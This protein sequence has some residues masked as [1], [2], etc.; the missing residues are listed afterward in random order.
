MHLSKK[1]QMAR[2]K[3]EQ[4][5]ILLANRIRLLRNEEAKTR[6]KIVETEK[7]TQEIIDARRRNEKRRQDKEAFEAHKEALE[8]EFRTKQMM[9]RADQQHK[10]QD[11]LRSIRERN[12][13]AGNVIRQER[14]AYQEVVDFERQAAAD[15]AFARAEQVRAAM[16]QAARTVLMASIMDVRMYLLLGANMRAKFSARA[17]FKP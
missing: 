14:Q 11:K 15:E 13:G 3:A 9:D 6:K 5:S 4:D 10:V 7:K 17:P 8:S 1:V 16:S 12:Q 2:K